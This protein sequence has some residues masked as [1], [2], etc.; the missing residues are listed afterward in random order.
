MKKT[1]L[2]FVMLLCAVTIVNA[3][4]LF[5]TDF[6]TTPPGFKAA[7]D[8]ATAATVDD[9]LVANPAGATAAKDTIIDSC[10]LSAPK[11]S[12][13]LTLILMS[14]ASQ[15][16]VKV[17]DTAGCTPGRLSLKNNGAFI[18]M[19]SVTGPCTI[20]YYA[21]ASSATAGRGVS[22]LINDVANTDASI[23][24]L[25]ILV[26]GVVTQVT[27]KKVYYYPTAGD[28]VFTLVAVGG[29]YL[30]DIKIES[31]NTSGTL[32]ERVVPH[33]LR[34]VRY[35]GSMIKNPN[36]TN[37]ELFTIT[38]A[39]V[40]TSD[41]SLIDLRGMVK[42]LYLIRVKGTDERMKILR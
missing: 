41:K 17:G 6:L 39:K 30:Y 40:L 33:Y 13:G 12:S 18:K 21:A 11:S 32:T 15:G 25:T 38:G 16:C 28:V 26:A 42:G 8:K 9:T 34:S 23:A 37:L 27:M 31:G 36:K 10:T 5:L 7:S 2:S 22:C 24:E 3:Q 35:E 4:V 29:V 1:I 19:P 20:T 14:K